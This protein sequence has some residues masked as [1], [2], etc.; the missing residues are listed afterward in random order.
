MEE[1]VGSGYI[2]YYRNEIES[3]DNIPLP[4][5]HTV[6]MAEIQAII[7]AGEYIL[8][9]P[10][11]HRFIKVLCDSQAA[12]LAF[13]NTEVKSKLVRKAINVWEEIAEKATRITFTWVKAHVGIEGNELADEEAKKGAKA[14]CKPTEEIIPW[15]H[16]K[17]EIEE[18]I[19]KEWKK[20]WENI[21]NHKNTKYFYDG[22]NKNK[23]KGVLAL[24]RG[25]LN[26]FIKAITGHNFL[27][28]HQHKI[29][30]NISLVC[31][32]CEEDKE[33]FWH[34]ID[35]CPRLRTLRE[36]IFLDNNITPDMAWSIRRI[37]RFIQHPTILDMMANKQGLSQIEENSRNIRHRL[38]TIDKEHG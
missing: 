27:G 28:Y 12:L 1:G 6:F 35:E 31:R 22:P 19:R 23:A 36:E 8:A 15:G 4:D 3:K 37:M 34:L 26:L 20:R 11:K 7:A 2:I 29:D 18:A 17:S 25:Y 13:K 14:I 30:P 10:N 16:K 24:S 21:H 9:N 33:T 5:T 32:I 38:L